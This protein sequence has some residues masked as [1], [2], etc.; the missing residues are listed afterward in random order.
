MGLVPLE[1]AFVYSNISSQSKL[2]L[3]KLVSDYNQRQTSV[4]TDFQRETPTASSAFF[5]THKLFQSILDQ[6]EVNAATHCDKGT[7][8]K[9]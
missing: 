5:D 1:T 9:E 8:C 7:N 4:M 2:E 6:S 3:K